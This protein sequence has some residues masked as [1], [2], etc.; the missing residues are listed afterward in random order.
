MH[1]NCAIRENGTCY[2]KQYPPA[3]TLFHFSNRAKTFPSF[4]RPLS[5]FYGRHCSLAGES[6]TI[7]DASTHIYDSRIISMKL[8][9]IEYA[10]TTVIYITRYSREAFF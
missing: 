5:R 1:G 2:R 6:G 7:G 8:P 10:L 4:F 9:L 3:S